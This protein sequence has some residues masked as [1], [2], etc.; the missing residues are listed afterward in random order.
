MK[1]DR[2]SGFPDKYIEEIPEEEVDVIETN[3]INKHLSNR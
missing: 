1:K 3:S 2:K